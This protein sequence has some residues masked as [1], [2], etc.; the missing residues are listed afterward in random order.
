M[1][2]TLSALALVLT[3][4]SASAQRVDPVK[5]G[6]FN[7]WVT[8]N[9]KESALIGGNTVKLY[10]I[11]PNT[12]VYGNKPYRPAGG[13]PW[14]TSNA[15]AKVSGIVK[16][17][18]AV[19]PA[20]RSGSNRCAKMCTMMERVKVLG[21]VNMDVMVAGTIFTGELIEPVT[22]TKNPYA[23]MVMGVPYSGHPSA[24]VF[25]CKLEMPNVNY[26]VK[27]TGFGSKKQLPG[28]DKAVAFIM[29]QRRWEDADGKLHALR[30][31]TGG[32]HFTSPTDWH[33]GV[34]VPIVYGNAS[35]S[36]GYA[37]FLA[38]RS[39]ANAYYARNS[40][41]ILTP[42]EE[43]GWDTSGAAP[44]HMII[45]FSSGDSEP[46]VGTEGMTFYIDNVGLKQ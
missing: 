21:V 38:L 35:H 41:G 12:A 39:G 23:K 2:F 33:N 29:L 13:S 30:V 43:E 14:A 1:K 5:Y 15:Y 8:R 32:R 27:S 34:E 10:E 6:D 31:G 16:G 44:T 37:P 24:L 3:L 7:S 4:L 36:P 25:D 19:F 28:R 42:I 46:Y 11:G 9:I 40:K 22:S 45:M 20:V 18:N 26:R 17:S